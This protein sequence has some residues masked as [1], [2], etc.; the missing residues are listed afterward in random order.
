M[1]EDK[2]Q[3][4]A[5]DSTKEK[6]IAIEWEMFQRVH[7]EG[8]RA[9]C[10]DRP[11]TFTIMR[12]AQFSA[13]PEELA[14]SYLDDLREALR[15]GRNL[16]MEKY[17]RMMASTAPEEYRRFSASL[18]QI[19]EH[20]RKMIDECVAQEISWMEEYC[21]KYPCLSAENRVLYS[22]EDTPYDTS[23]E[24]YERGELATYSERTLEL[25]RK[26]LLELRE[27]GGNLALLTMTSMVRQYGYSSLE[28]A[29]KRLPGT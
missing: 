17:A 15:T 22:R 4:N 13:W 3:D 29:E 23:F 1:S 20:C 28:D 7:N 26:F 21:R 8:G 10:Q 11:D 19:S 24:T 27:Q 14:E 9:D 18:P 6:I 12:R 16:P 2:A 5:P 25:Y